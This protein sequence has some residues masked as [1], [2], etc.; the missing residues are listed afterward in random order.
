MVIQFKIN[1]IHSSPEISWKKKTNIS[2][3]PAQ[4]RSSFLSNLGYINQHRVNELS[5]C[6]NRSSIKIEEKLGSRIELLQR[7]PFVVS[8]ANARPYRGQQF[9]ET[10]STQT[11]DRWCGIVSIHPTLCLWSRNGVENRPREYHSGKLDSGAAI[12]WRTKRHRMSEAIY[13]SSRGGKKKGVEEKGWK[14][15]RE[16]R[17]AG[18]CSNRRY[19]AC[20]LL[21]ISRLVSEIGKEVEAYFIRL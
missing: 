3:H 2:N 13:T 1:S 9:R 16:G 12:M 7:S 11:V 21:L 10:I 5:R 4:F 17:K 6:R 18:K 14:R 15:G 20:T 8:S 19:H